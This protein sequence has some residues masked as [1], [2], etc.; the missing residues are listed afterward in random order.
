MNQDPKT[1]EGFLKLC[2]TEKSDTPT[3]TKIGDKKLGIFAG[4]YSIS[5]ENEK[6]FYNLYHKEV[7]IN[8]KPAYL[9]ESQ[10][11]D[12]GP[13][14]VD[15]DE[16]YSSDITERQHTDE[17]INDLIGLYIDK[18]REITNIGESITFPVFIMEK[19]DINSDNPD[20][21]K[22]GIHIYFGL[23]FDTN[24]K[25]LLRK[26]VI[27]EI[28]DV[29]GDLPLIN[30]YE[31]LIDFGIARAT[32]NWQVFGSRKPGHDAYK[33]K[34]HFHITIRGV[35]SDDEDEDEEDLIEYNEI[36]VDINTD[37]LKLLPIMSCKNKDL[38]KPELKD[39]I[40][41]HLSNQKKKIKVKKPKI[42]LINANLNNI[43][44][45]QN[46]F[47][48]IDSES[49]CRSIINYILNYAKENENFE[50]EYAHNLTMTLNNEYYDPYLYWMK[51]ALILK[52]ISELLYPTWLLF[53]SKSD[54]FSW[55][56][57]DCYD[58]WKN[59]SESSNKNEVIGVGSLK[60]WAI[61]CNAAR[62]DEID[63]S[64][65]DYY[66]LKTLA[67]TAGEYDIAKLVH[68]IYQGTFK[69]CNI[70]KKLWYE[71]SDE[72]WSEIDSGTTLREALSKKISKIFYKKVVSAMKEAE[73]IEDDDEKK[74]KHSEIFKLSELAMNLNKT[75]WKQNIMREA[76]E[77]FFDKAFL[78]KLDTNPDLL[79]FKNGVLDMENKIFRKGDPNDYISLSTNRNYVTFDP[80]NEEHVRIREEII[81]FMRQLFPNKNLN[82]YM[83]EHLASTLRGK[84]RNQTF[85]I[86]TGTGRN[87][88][89]KL[90]T[91]MGMVL[92]DYKG[93][94]PLTL[95]TRE[96]SSLGSVTPEVAQLQ[97]IRFAVMQEPSKKTKLN[98][99]PMK[100]LVGEDPIQGRA[101]YKDT[102]TFIPQFKLVVCTNHLF[103]ITSTDDG[104]WRRIRVCDFESKFLDDPSDDPA[105]KEFKVDRNIDSKFEEWV[106]IFTAMLV[107]KLFETD[108]IV[109]DCPEVMAASMRYKAQQDHFAGFIKERISKHEGGVI[110]RSDVKAEFEEW[111][112][113]LY[114]GK[115]PSGKE[116]Y[117]YLTKELGEPNK[118]GWTGYT[119]YHSYDLVDDENIKAN[120]V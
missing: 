32:C 110:K 65:I 68:A 97:G 12:V 82:K 94:V 30:S 5:K 95:I 92:G 80:E 59:L 18:I 10:D 60:F 35:N 7:F 40:K 115:I 90:V 69:C 108:G 36:P 70:P 31:D 2:K 1:L 39:E 14:V 47:P 88:K 101:L 84:N 103:D 62:V 75:S 54:K 85:N 46:S 63:Q 23:L 44:D 58:F 104:T 79:C 27:E 11:R 113:E 53:S 66:L 78:N 6:K 24:A 28:E 4:S 33:L 8:K 93:S 41:K 45:C 83:W 25:I 61:K 37:Y 106:P 56:D 13:L 112:S 15:V 67:P 81:E 51:V 42:N 116:L 100:E 17:H 105:D 109:E 114:S 98:E 111:Y 29:I 9:T 49:R 72:K 119:L 71:Y 48:L 87:G 96:R 77:V 102:V 91:L 43:V 117:E 19:D 55:S 86:Y 21:V 20:Y 64:N 16:R 107:E 50:I 3:H 38:N 89:S 73:S 57:N 74:K 76:Q 99:G 52:D 34:K 120:A 22:D 118:K 26:L